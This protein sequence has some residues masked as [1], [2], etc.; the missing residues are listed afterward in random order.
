MTALHPDAPP[1][2]SVHVPLVGATSVRFAIPRADEDD[3]WPLSRALTELQRMGAEREG[4]PRALGAGRGVPLVH[5]QELRWHGVT[6]VLEALHV[7][8]GA[9][10]EVILGLPAWDELEQ[11]LPSEEELWTLVDTVAAA[12]EA[13]HGALGDGEAFLLDT[14]EDEAAWQRRLARHT[15]LLVT[16]PPSTFAATACPYRTLPRSGLT[17]LLR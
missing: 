3:P 16:E 4:S 1:A 11:A 17:V 10:D 5:S 8:G 2:W 6:L 13:R 9:F 7:Q 15:G 14:P 12:C